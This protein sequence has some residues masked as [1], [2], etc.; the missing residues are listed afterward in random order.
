M[1]DDLSIVFE[2]TSRAWRGLGPRAPAG[3]G[4][5]L[6]ELRAIY[7]Y[8]QG[9]IRIRFER[10]FAAIGRSVLGEAIEVEALDQGP[11]SSLSHLLE[12]VGEVFLDRV[13]R[14][15]ERT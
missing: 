6:Q 5:A 3:I 11:P 8:R 15:I 9:L 14:D 7:L 13:L 1:V 4:P 10:S 12:D 2:I